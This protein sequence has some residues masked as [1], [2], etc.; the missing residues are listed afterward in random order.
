MGIGI[1]LRAFSAGLF[2]KNKAEKIR[3]ILDGGEL[4]ALEE[5]SPSPDTNQV[6]AAPKKPIRSDAI[7]LLSS[8]QR[9]ARLVDLI[10]EDLSGFSDEQVGAAARPCLQQSAATLKRLLNLAPVCD[11]ADGST[12]DVAPDES[13]ARY[14]WSGE[15]ASNSG[16]LIHHG[17][18]ATQIELPTYTGD[19]ADA[20]LIAPAQVQR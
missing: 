5:K 20:L 7:T 10:Q 9:E 12:V 2:D 15:G 4:P 1:A 17:W 18:Q 3:L 16:S 13:A 11:A 19:A 8:L 6:S 14:Q